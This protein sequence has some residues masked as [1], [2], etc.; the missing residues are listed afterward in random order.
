MRCRD[1]ADASATRAM[2]PVNN[3]K[4][5]SPTMPVQQRRRY[6]RNAGND[7]NTGKDIIMM[8]AATV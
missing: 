1:W 2:T 7:V 4:D 3:G 6:Q 8:L 5:A